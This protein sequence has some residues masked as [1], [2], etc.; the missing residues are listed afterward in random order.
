[1]T[2][3]HQETGPQADLDRAERDWRNHRASRSPRPVA[4]AA[5][6]LI[7]AMANAPERELDL[8]LAGKLQDV[9]KGRPVSPEVVSALA[10]GLHAGGC[11]TTADR[12]AVLAGADLGE[13]VRRRQ[14]QD[15]ADQLVAIVADRPPIT[16][17]LMEPP[18]F[19]KLRRRMRK[20]IVAAYPY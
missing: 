20:L 3:N 4:F 19:R 11:I 8:W 13:I 16:P 14:G 15:F 12:A 18:R 10:A 7:E 17:R 6:H 1:M 2:K 5:N 9:T